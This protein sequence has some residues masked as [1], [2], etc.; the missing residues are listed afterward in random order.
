MSSEFTVS[1]FAKIN[2]PG[3][4]LQM[5]TV[6]ARTKF[7]IRPL[8]VADDWSHRKTPA[9]VV[10]DPKLER[11]DAVYGKTQ[12]IFDGNLNSAVCGQPA[13]SALGL[14]FNF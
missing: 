1:G 10:V 5:R 11:T 3:G 14:K 4:R 2:L 12:N 13:V 6:H 9:N 7:H 8:L